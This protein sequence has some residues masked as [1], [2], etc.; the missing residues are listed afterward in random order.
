MKPTQV[1][2]V[3]KWWCCVGGQVWHVSCTRFI[4]LDAKLLSALT[5]TVMQLNSPNQAQ[6]PCPSYVNM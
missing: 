3:R 5:C 2:A 1:D 4:T 6:V